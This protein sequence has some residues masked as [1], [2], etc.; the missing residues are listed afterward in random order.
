ESTALRCNL[1]QVSDAR[2][3]RTENSAGEHAASSDGPWH[4]QGR[5]R[6][7]SRSPSPVICYR[8]EAQADLPLRLQCSLAYIAVSSRGSDR[9]W[10]TM[11]AFDAPGRT[12]SSVT[13]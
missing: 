13:T 7:G 10:R 6:A 2:M 9:S 5:A 8:R 12:Q 3:A 1:E 4:G 11:A